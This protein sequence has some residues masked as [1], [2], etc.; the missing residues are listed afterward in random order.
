M[1]RSNRPSAQHRT[2]ACA[3]CLL[4]VLALLLTPAPALA[5][6][7][8]LSVQEGEDILVGSDAKEALIAFTNFV[9][10]PGIPGTRLAV[11]RG[12]GRADERLS[13]LKGS[14]QPE[15]DL[16]SERWRLRLDGGLGY[17]AATTPIDI[18]NGTE[19]VR[20]DTERQLLSGRIGAGG[21]YLW[22]E[23]V[24][25]R[26]MLSVAVS[27]IKSTADTNGVIP[28]ARASQAD[29]IDWRVN[30]ASLFGSLEIDYDQFWGDTRWEVIGTYSH[31]Y[32]RSYNASRGVIEFSGHTDTIGA[33]IRRSAHTGAD[34]FSIPLDWNVF[35]SYTGFIG[36]D[37]DVLGFNSLLSVGAGLDLRVRKRPFDIGNLRSVGLN[38]SAVLGENVAGGTLGI[39]FRN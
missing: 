17:V 12:G 6:A 11:N 36:L 14:L 37:P 33:L 16:P 22:F 29:I 2:G 23:H 1:S 9:I 15:F 8:T 24:D 31:G 5:Q 38:F 20:F 32:H 27:Q 30:V 35:A 34:L 28:F 19:P 39:S 4:S 7:G 18:S 26:P 21:S 10:G 13:I 3:A 25:V